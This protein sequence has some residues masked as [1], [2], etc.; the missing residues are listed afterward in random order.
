MNISYNSLSDLHG[1]LIVDLAK[2]DFEPKIKEEFK[3]VR[4]TASVK[5]F[6][7]GHVPESMLQSMYGSAIRAEVI[8]KLVTE[9]VTDYQKNNAIK[10]LGDLLP[11]SEPLSDE[12]F[13]S[14]N[15]NFK[16]E[17]G[18]S[19]V[20][21]SE[22]IISQI[23]VDKYIIT[24]DDQECIESLE[25]IRSKAPKVVE[26]SSEII[27]GDL[28]EL[29]L[30]EQ[31]GANDK[32]GGWESEL[33]IGL[34]NY[35]TD[36]FISNFL[37]KKTGDSVYININNVEKD[38]NPEMVRKYLLKIPEASSNIEVG[39]MY[40]ATISRI[41]VNEPSD[42]NEEFFDKTFGENSGVKTKE[43][44]INFIKEDLGKF[45]AEQAKVLMHHNV[46]HKI[47][48]DC[49]IKLPDAFLKKWLKHSF[50]EWSEISNDDFEH[51]YYHYR[52]SMIWRLLR[53]QLVEKNNITAEYEE[54]ENSVIDS[55][56]KQYPGINL[57]YEQWRSIAAKNMGNQDFVME[58]YNN[59]ITN[60]SLDWLTE[61]I[62]T[63][64]KIVSKEE[65][66]ALV[67]EINNHEG[68]VHH[69]H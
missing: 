47:N 56:R 2:T 57:P 36:E 10:L 68:H 33:M 9:M 35:A 38:S 29:K 12:D 18:L 55:F 45:Y 17:V 64:D 20:I 22:T 13:K 31:E 6:R 34:D 63:T 59:V 60:K 15:L 67:A 61:N 26:K 69:E 43:D 24:V 23:D 44:A 48:H 66:K 39:E 40:R 11:M 62:K 3:K 28:L 54:V 65:Y 14:D 52:E 1:E 42:L 49:G 25:S 30:V 19:P 21:S 16:F 8:N 4:K 50:K 41:T 7:A 58:H 51:K 53:D 32:P 46:L 37:G 5:G 27:S